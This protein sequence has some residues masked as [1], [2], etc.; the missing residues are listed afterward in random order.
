MIQ[1]GSRDSTGCTLS[2]GS[3]R[4][5]LAT[6]ASLPAPA[7][8]LPQEGGRDGRQAGELRGVRAAA[9]EDEPEVRDA[10]GHAAPA[11]LRGQSGGE[12]VVAVMV[13]QT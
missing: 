5:D 1:F 3:D 9:G 11:L 6:P 4:P 10:S 7:A 12:E 2:S 8:A 13:G